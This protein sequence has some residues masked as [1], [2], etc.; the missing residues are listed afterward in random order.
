MMEI[1][2]IND[3]CV[4]SKAQEEW[5]GFGNMSG[6]FPLRIN[7][8]LLIPSVEN[9]YQAMRYTDDPDRQLPILVQKSGFSAKLVAK[10]WRNEH[11]RPDFNEVRVQI[12][13][14]CLQIKKRQHKKYRDLLISTGN[15]PI[16]EIS[17][18]DD[19]WGAKPNED[20]TIFTG[21]NT[22]GKLHME[23]RDQ[24]IAN[25]DPYVTERVDPVNIP[26]FL[27]LGVDV[28]NLFPCEVEF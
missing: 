26:N 13:R 19:F 24:L 12:M 25:T 23:I 27:L 2:H 8:Q 5:G 22:L 16:V 20:W 4:F 11:T 17:K 3:V 1:Y 9:L 10:K 6:G 28:S 18:K 21:N 14:W 7:P 15:R